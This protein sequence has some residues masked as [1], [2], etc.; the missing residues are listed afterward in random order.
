MTKHIQL[1]KAIGNIDDDIAANAI[2]AAQHKRK[3]L[4]LIIIGTIV[5]AAVIVMGCA[6]VIRS[7]LMF[8]DK[9]VLEFNY[10]PLTQ[11]HIPTVDELKEL[12]TVTDGKYYSGSY[13][14]TALPSELFACFNVAPLMNAEFFSEERSEL[15]VKPYSTQTILQYTLTDKNSNKPINFEI[16]FHSEGE[17]SFSMG[18]QLLGDGKA[19]DMFSHY[20]FITLSDGSQALAAD[21]YLHGYE[22]YTAEAVLCYNGIGYRINAR[23]VDINEMKQILANLGA[24]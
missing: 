3:P 2:E 6:T 5:A 19:T 11:A 21:R 10:Y 12:G 22:Y 20:E 17:D 14:L 15:T 8:D 23:N 18:Y 16:Q 13:T 24:M 1:F 7:S 4:K 9:P